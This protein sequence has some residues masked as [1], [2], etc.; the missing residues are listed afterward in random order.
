M[1]IPIARG[2]AWQALGWRCAPPAGPV[3][4]LQP[5][6]RAHSGLPQSSPTR[7]VNLP[8]SR[9][10]DWAAAGPDR[11]IEGI[12]TREVEVPFREDGQVWWR[13]PEEDETAPSS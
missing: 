9:A 8:P 3:G 12:E 6:Q 4:D 1:A 11:Y 7:Q 10:R 2:A 5:G 13:G